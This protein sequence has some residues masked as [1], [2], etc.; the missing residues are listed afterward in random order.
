MY[1][2]SSEKI[3]EEMNIL[4]IINKMRELNVLIKYFKQDPVI[5]KEFS[6]D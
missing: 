1:Y 4:Y 2:M 5:K 3:D 6:K